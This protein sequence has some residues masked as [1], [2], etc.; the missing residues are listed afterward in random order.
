MKKTVK[1]HREK[2]ETMKDATKGAEPHLIDCGKATEK[3]KGVY[4]FPA[5]AGGPPYNKIYI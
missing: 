3:T 4:G 5:E 2:K 1:T